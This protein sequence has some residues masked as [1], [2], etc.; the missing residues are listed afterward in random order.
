MLAREL[1]DVLERIV[2]AQRN[3]P[4]P[5]PCTAILWHGP[6]H[7]SQSR[8]EITGPHEVHETHY[9]PGDLARW[10]TGDYTGR[11]REQGIDFDPESYPED[12]GMTGF[13]DEPPRGD[14]A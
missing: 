13:F 11:L 9:G 8:C 1:E 3:Y 7:Q 14:D 2:Q 4:K 5:E 6:G 12:M 10:R